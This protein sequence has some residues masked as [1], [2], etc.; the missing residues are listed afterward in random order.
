[1]ADNLA[2]NFDEQNASHPLVETDRPEQALD[3]K[4]IVELG[5]TPPR[6]GAVNQLEG[7]AKVSL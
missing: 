5:A 1:L 3:I 4:E 6:A 2:D 7:D